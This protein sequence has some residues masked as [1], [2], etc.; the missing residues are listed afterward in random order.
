METL[1]DEGGIDLLFDEFC[2]SIAPPEAT[3]VAMDLFNSMAACGAGPSS[4]SAGQ[5]SSSASGER[6]EPPPAAPKT[7][8]WGSWA[9]V[10][11]TPP[12]PLTQEGEEASAK[13]PKKG[14]RGQDQLLII[15]D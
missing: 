4:G 1:L 7:R 10:V 9:N 13:T 12:V 2:Q 14:K 6:M 5:P 11:A 15:I 3:G 8:G